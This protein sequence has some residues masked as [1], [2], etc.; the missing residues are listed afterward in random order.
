MSASTRSGGRSSVGESVRTQVRKAGYPMHI[1]FSVRIRQP[2]S[3]VSALVVDSPSRWFPKSVGVH[4]MG[5]PLRKRIKVQF[6]EPAKIST[7]AVIPMSWKPTFGQRFLPAMNGKVDLS[8]VSK[9]ETRLTV[10][11]MYEPPLGRFGEQLDQGVLHNVAKGTVKELAQ[12]IAR[13]L[14][15]A[16]RS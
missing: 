16:S 7:W 4:V 3:L 15:K 10:S 2:L 9:D 14:E 1:Q 8:P 13:R 11:G 5:L 6:G 12:L